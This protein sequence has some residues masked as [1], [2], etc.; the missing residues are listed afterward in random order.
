MTTQQQAIGIVG[1]KVGMTRIFNEDG[2]SVPVT[3]IH[4][5]SNFVTQIKA[6]ETDGYLAAQVSYG[7]Q[8][9]N[10]VN[11]P[12]KGHYQKAG[13]EMG[14]GLIEFL[15]DPKQAEHFSLG[16]EITLESFDKVP[17][18]D[19]SGV[20]KGKG[21]AGTVKRHHFSMQDAT[22]GNSLSHRAPGSIGQ[23]QTPGRVFKGKK[24]S[25]HLGHV[26]RTIQSLKI[27]RLD[28]EKNVILIKG[29]C[30]GPIGGWLVIKPA[31]KIPLSESSHTK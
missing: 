26:Q 9:V 1:Q 16:Q 12:C 29:G 20:T 3:V 13:V 19:V 31:V 10:R 22:H 15:L 23:R 28:L 7:K 27:V 8:S 17:Y 4:V 30:P 21:F 24:M 25:G 2:A 6:I 5:P 14:L 11:K 18:V